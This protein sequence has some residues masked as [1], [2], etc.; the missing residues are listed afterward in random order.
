ML[1]VWGYGPQ[2]N[3]EF[4]QSQDSAF[5]V[6]LLIKLSSYWKLN[7]GIIANPVLVSDCFIRVGDCSIRVF[8]IFAANNG[9]WGWME[10]GGGK[11][12]HVPPVP[13]LNLPLIWSAIWFCR[14]Y[15]YTYKISRIQTQA[16]NTFII[17][18]GPHKF[19]RWSCRWSHAVPLKASYLWCFLVAR[20]K[21]C[22]G[23]SNLHEIWAILL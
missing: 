14:I 16:Q 6:L 20:P 9:I 4:Y 11:G 7:I 19:S 18:L 17:C 1:G 3:F 22:Q 2:E 23:C 12:G 21:A 15:F 5:S 13:P 8:R 10:D